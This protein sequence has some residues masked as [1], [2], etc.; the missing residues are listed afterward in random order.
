M[1]R[2]SSLAKLAAVT[3]LLLLWITTPRKTPASRPNPDACI[4]IKPS[5]WIPLTDA[6]VEQY[7]RDASL[8]IAEAV[9]QQDTAEVKAVSA[10]QMRSFSA[11][12][13]HDGVIY[14]C[15]ERL[16][17]DGT[18]THF[19]VAHVKIEL[20]QRYAELARN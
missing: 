12:E 15:P 20:K 17:H 8:S 6:H 18:N 2:Y 14:L 7:A 3:C 10:A 5:S 16:T 13:W 9:N 1:N 19:D 4:V 11:S